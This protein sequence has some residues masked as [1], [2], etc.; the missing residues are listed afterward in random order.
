MNCNPTLTADEFKVIHNSLYYLDCIGNEQVSKIVEEMRGAL[1]GAYDQDNDAFGRKHT[2]FENFRQTNGLRAIWSIYE[3]DEHGFLN[4]HPFEGADR[5]VYQDHWGEK[6]VSC[7]IDGLTW[8]ALY[9]AADACISGSG[10]THHC[11]IESFV[12]DKD[13]PRTLIL[14]T[15]S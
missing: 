14:S 4:P 2:Y 13:D 6:P 8:S 12:P 1:R 10:D 7:S 11:F 3:L 9:R 15:G 5:V